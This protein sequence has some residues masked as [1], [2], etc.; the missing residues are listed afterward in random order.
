V[1]EKPEGW[2]ATACETPSRNRIAA[3]SPSGGQSMVVARVSG[4]RTVTVVRSGEP[5]HH[6]LEVAGGDGYEWAA[7]IAASPPHAFD[8]RR[9]R[10]PRPQSAETF[11][12]C[13]R[14]SPHDHLIA[15]LFPMR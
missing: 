13:V 1:I 6:E 15:G 9:I 5:R 14:S 4:P 2:E 8:V 11:S 12:G 10:W 3:H 7:A